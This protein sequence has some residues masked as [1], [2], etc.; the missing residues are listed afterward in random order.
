MLAGIVGM[1]NKNHPGVMEKEAPML[2][3]HMAKVF[4]LPK[5]REWIMRRPKKTD[6]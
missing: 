3:R 2:Y 4:G 5:L 1:I 6:F